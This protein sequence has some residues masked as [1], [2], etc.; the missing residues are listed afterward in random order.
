VG[1]LLSKIGRE[2]KRLD[3]A[4]RAM[5]ECSAAIASGIVP[6]DKNIRLCRLDK[7]GRRDLWARIVSMLKARGRL[8]ADKNE[9][10]S[11]G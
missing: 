4:R 11:R 2:K 10:V 5:A 9:E 3:S 8:P 6:S 1:R 7:S